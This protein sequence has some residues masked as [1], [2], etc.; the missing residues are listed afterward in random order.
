[1]AYVM[2]SIGFPWDSKD[3]LVKLVLP[4][5][6]K[7]KGLVFDSYYQEAQL[8]Y[9]EDDTTG[10]ETSWWFRLYND[11]E[12]IKEDESQYI[13]SMPTIDGTFHMFFLRRSY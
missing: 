5:N 6:A 8:V 11:S 12:E 4:E 13:G 1:M 2:K 7:I 3:G 10:V 9:V